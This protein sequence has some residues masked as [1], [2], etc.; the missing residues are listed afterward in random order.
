MAAPTQAITYGDK[1]GTGYPNVGAMLVNI[2]GKERQ[3]CSGTLISPTVFLT[4][5]HCTASVESRGISEVFVSFDSELRGDSKRIVGRMHTNPGFNRSQSD[6]GDIAVITFTEPVDGITP[7]KLPKA[8][9]F[10]KL[11]DKNGLKGQEFIAVGYGALE[12]QTGGGQPTFGADNFRRVA[13]STF[14]ALNSAWLRL[15]QN[16][17]T[18]DAGTCY[19]DSGGPNFLGRTNTIA[20][21]TV[22]G[23]A[24]CRAMNVTLRLDTST[25]RDFLKKHVTLH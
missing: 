7:A 24:V 23:D 15:S 4:A 17:A 10:D 16:P 6:P 8:G 20:S 14:D 12:R 25:A 13:V 21:I 19:G 2:E 9:Q 18:G 5:A 11:A 22:T 3:Y 1:D